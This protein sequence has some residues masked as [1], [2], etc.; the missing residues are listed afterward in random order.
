MIRGCACPQA[1]R[2]PGTGGTSQYDLRRIAH[3][4][5]KG[6]CHPAWT[7]G[8]SESVARE[9]EALLQRLP[10]HGPGADPSVSWA[11]S[12][13]AEYHD[14]QRT[15][16]TAR[17]A[18]PCPDPGSDFIDP[19]IRLLRSRRSIRNYRDRRVDDDVLAGVLGLINWCPTSCN[20]QPARVYAVRS[21]AMVAAVMGR[22]AGSNGFSANVPCALV[23]CADMR[24]YAMPMEMFLP[25]IDVALGIQNC[26]LV[27]HARG[28]SLTLMSWAHHS[29]ADDKGLRGDLGIPEWEQILVGGLLGYPAVS[30][31]APGRKP[32]SDTV[33]VV[34][35]I[36]S[37]S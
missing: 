37:R 26:A 34:D 9:L 6:L 36:P 13:L 31:P 20:R 18:E 21:P 33:T 30:M 24:A 4:L 19:L 12:V 22:F 7:P 29:E 1:D 14:A 28:L 11:R 23:F 8:H 35:Q 5:E 32:A 27:A 2:R 15:G 16:G 3:I 25:G 17:N 10:E